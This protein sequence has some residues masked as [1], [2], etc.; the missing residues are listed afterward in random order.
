M[1]ETNRQRRENRR[2]RGAALVEYGQAVVEL[3]AAA[4]VGG[5]SDNAA[6]A[7]LLEV[8]FDTLRACIDRMED[9]RRRV[10]TLEQEWSRLAAER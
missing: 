8:D 6:A 2:L 5:G 7:R 10:V 9:A 4:R 3:L 1:S